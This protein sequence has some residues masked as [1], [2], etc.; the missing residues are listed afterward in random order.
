MLADGSGVHDEFQP[1][2]IDSDMAVPSFFK[3][4][5]S[6][7]I[8]AALGVI[9]S[10][11][12]S[13]EPNIAEQQQQQLLQRSSSGAQ[14]SVTG[15][16][17]GN[18][19]NLSTLSEH[20]SFEFRAAIPSAG[21]AQANTGSRLGLETG[22][23]GLAAGPCGVA[24]A[25]T[26][27]GGMELGMVLHPP[28]APAPDVA[29]GG[30]DGIS[31]S[32]LAGSGPALSASGASTTTAAAAMAAA[33]RGAA[34]LPPHSQSLQLQQ[35]S[36]LSL[37]AQ[38]QA[39]MRAQMQQLEVLQQHTQMQQMHLQQMQKSM[40]IVCASSTGIGGGGDRGG[41][42]IDVSSGADTFSPVPLAPVLLPPQ[43]LQPLSQHQQTFMPLQSHQQ[44]QKQQDQTAM[45]Y[46]SMAANPPGGMGPAVGHTGGGGGSGSG[47]AAVG[48]SQAASPQSARPLQPPSH[49]P[50]PGPSLGLVQLSNPR[51]CK[52]KRVSYTSG[53]SDYNASPISASPQ[54]GLSPS[55][56]VLVGQL[57]L[58]RDR[59]PTRGVDAVVIPP[60]TGVSSAPSSPLNLQQQQLQLLQLQQQQRL[61]LQQQQQLQLYQQ[62]QKMQQGA[63][64][65][66]LSV[67]GATGALPANPAGL[68][69]AA[70]AAQLGGLPPCQPASQAGLPV[71]TGGGGSSTGQV[72]SQDFYALGSAAE[73]GGGSNSDGDPHHQQTLHHTGS[74]GHQFHNGQTMRDKNREAQRR[75]RERQRGTLALL[76]SRAEEQAQAIEGLTREKRMVEQHNKMLLERIWK[77]EA[78]L[79]DAQAQ[80]RQLEMQ[81][82]QRDQ[83]QQQDHTGSASGEDGV[84]DMLMDGKDAETVVSEVPGGDRVGAVIQGGDTSRTRQSNTGS[85][86]PGP[87]TMGCRPTG[88][89]TTRGNG[90][91]KGANGDDEC[92]GRATGGDGVAALLP[93]S[94]QLNGWPT[95]FTGLAVGCGFGRND[96]DMDMFGLEPVPAAA[97]SPASGG[98]DGGAVAPG[99]VEAVVM[100]G[101]DSARVS[102]ASECRIDFASTLGLVQ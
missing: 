83:Q 65:A 27:S 59:P 75:Y 54:G 78:S 91:V 66:M 61:Q 88:S 4:S 5:F 96:G 79:S 90:D 74:S 76:Q 57:S 56:S 84:R 48:V 97:D 33:R 43:T 99:G 71:A 53:Y 34:G 100:D 2:V 22:L 32:A 101:G 51:P 6:E 44:Q 40:Q 55:T 30:V 47:A 37:Q 45:F 3:P 13:L 67:V 64:S 70:T 102:S 15:N 35:Q 31:L 93:S 52:S 62:Q 14:L 68:L 11:E 50:A 69:V 17:S 20:F 94:Y 9:D 36:D 46:A 89:G 1:V 86:G 29:S 18:P 24:N 81:I 58:G 73:G 8:E 38:L 39:H 85:P 98:N 60:D 87:G 72:P 25:E 77:L 23:V 7:F 26:D 16:V 80:V 19:S 95:A 12:G 82:Q 92:R 63:T 42:G 10:R 41:G 21:A 28:V 49:A